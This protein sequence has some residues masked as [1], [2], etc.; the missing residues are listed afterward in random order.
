[1]TFHDC[2]TYVFSMEKKILS[3]KNKTWKEGFVKSGDRT[4]AFFEDQNAK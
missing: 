2:D 1:M 4:H 3:K